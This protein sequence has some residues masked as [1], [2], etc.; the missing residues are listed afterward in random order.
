MF[1]I[2]RFVNLNAIPKRI[3]MVW[4]LTDNTLA[5]LLQTVNLLMLILLYQTRHKKK[6]LR[7]TFFT[8][9]G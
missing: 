7:L 6:V 3:S 5:F 1:S 4:W 9:K 8:Y 2:E